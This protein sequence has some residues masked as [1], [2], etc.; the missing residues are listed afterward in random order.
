MPP[1]VIP[2]KTGIRVFQKTTFLDPGFHR[3]DEKE[4]NTITK[5][6]F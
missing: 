1:H 4:E 6:L 3:D 2:V 5:P